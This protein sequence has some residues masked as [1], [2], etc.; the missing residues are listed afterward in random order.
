MR[1]CVLARTVR[2]WPAHALLLCGHGKDENTGWTGDPIRDPVALWRDDVKKKWMPLTAGLMLAA[3]S[4]PY[5]VAATRFF[6]HPENLP[7]SLGGTRIWAPAGF[8]V[9]LP[10]LLPLML[11]MVS[12]LIRRTWGLVVAC[13]VMPLVFTI[14]L[15]PWTETSIAKA[16][17]FS[18]TIPYGACNLLEFV[19]Y[20]LMVAAA[21]LAVVSR[22]T[23]FS[24][25]ESATEYLYGPPKWWH[26]PSS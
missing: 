15:S 26:G 5:F 8:V 9:W 16:L 10:F 13:A 12:A 17:F 1:V 3:A 11:G 19:T 21:V 7:G 2:F 20:T 6:F 22:K 14:L 4:V 25:R 24:G 18:T 23:A